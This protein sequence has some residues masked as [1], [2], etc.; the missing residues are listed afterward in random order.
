MKM[1]NNNYITPI[2]SYSN[3]NECKLTVYKENKYKSG[4][5]R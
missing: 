3:A 1:N 2:V 5:Y 4:V